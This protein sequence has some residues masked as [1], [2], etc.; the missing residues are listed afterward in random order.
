MSSDLPG[1]RLIAGLWCGDVLAALPDWLEGGLSPELQAAARAHLAGCDWCE[2][3]GGRYGAVVTA[4]R[5]EVRP[6]MPAGAAQR[7]DERLAKALRGQT[8]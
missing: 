8:G 7:L 4:L 3:F 2:R 6:A 5:A 1:P